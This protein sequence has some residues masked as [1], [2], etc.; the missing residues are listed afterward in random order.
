MLNNDKLV[1]INASIY[2]FTKLEEVFREYRPNI[3]N[4]HAAQKSVP[5][6]MD[7][8]YLNL[9]INEVGLLNLIMLTKNIRLINLFMCPVV[10]RCQKKF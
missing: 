10:E 7:D 4:H 2:D 8:P 6:S 1:F 3:I 5:D 9:K